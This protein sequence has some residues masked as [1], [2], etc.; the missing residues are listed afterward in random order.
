M[1][2]CPPRA[3][4]SAMLVAAAASGSAPLVAHD[5]ERTHV[6]LT[7]GRDGRFDLLV[8]NDPRWL[9]LRLERFGERW[10]AADV[11]AG[12][13]A[14]AGADGRLAAL[15]PIFKDRV[16]LFVDGHEI[17]PDTV[18]FVPPDPRDASS[19]AGYRL[20]GSMAPGAASLR[21]F[22]G[23][24]ID[25]YPLVL[26][27][28]DGTRT[29]ETVLGD[30]WSGP[31][32]LLGPSGRRTFWQQVRAPLALGFSRI[33]PNGVEHVLFVLGLLLLGRPRRMPARLALFVALCAL[34]LML[35]ASGAIPHAPRVAGWLTALSIVAVG[36]ANVVKRPAAVWFGPLLA[37][38]GSVHGWRLAGTFE[39]AGLPESAHAIVRLSF[40][41]G[42]MIALLAAAGLALVCV[43]S[44]QDRA[45]Y[46]RRIVVPASVAM[47]C[48]G[49]YWTMLR[50]TG[51]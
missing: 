32:E 2:F 3:L 15:A 42:S 43:G 33:L 44:Y 24:V 41:A 17:R 22:Y 13:E 25:P 34:V 6:A 20:Q 47:L 39:D 26:T 1:P 46:R 18:T 16:V 31:I 5:L 50:A 19:L 35:G 11:P 23:L 10:S 40:T 27:R 8:S 51:V 37:I 45:W 21:W 30:A 38:A 49:A 29:T 12:A 36:A 48:A 7:L 4:V 14:G 28:A 9:L